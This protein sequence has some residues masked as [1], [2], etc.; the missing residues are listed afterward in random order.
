MHAPLAPVT[1][2]TPLDHFNS[3]QDIG[4]E[5]KE[6]LDIRIFTFSKSNRNIEFPL[7]I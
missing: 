2:T 4:R 3:P 7:S 1:A 6:E 5:E